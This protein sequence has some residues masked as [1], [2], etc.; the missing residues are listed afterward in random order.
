MSKI[1]LTT[2]R[3]RNLR[4]AKNRPFL[5]L[6]GR[7]S[8]TRGAI[9]LTTLRHRLRVIILIH[10]LF[11]RLMRRK[12]QE[13]LQGNDVSSVKASDTYKPIVQIES[14]LIRVKWSLSI[15]GFSMVI[16]H[17]FVYFCGFMFVLM[18]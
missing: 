3:S 13:M 1:L 11:L 17:S 4:R 5:L 8:Q 14:P 7:I 2:P 15:I 6:G 9:V 16:L 10:L 18:L 12:F